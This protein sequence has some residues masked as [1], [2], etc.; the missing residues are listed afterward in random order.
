MEEMKYIMVRRNGTQTN[1]N[2]RPFS[3]C[4]FWRM[5]QESNKSLPLA[6][7][8]CLGVLHLSKPSVWR[9]PP[10]IKVVLHVCAFPVTVFIGLCY[11]FS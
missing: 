7:V 9:H 4:P 10:R 5:L 3:S 8:V 1:G 6:F 2:P 11:S